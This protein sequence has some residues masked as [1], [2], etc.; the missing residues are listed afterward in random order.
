[1]NIKKLF[2][3]I[4]AFSI[5]LGYSNIGRA[6]VT[7]TLPSGQIAATI[8]GELPLGKIGLDLGDLGG[9]VGDAVSQS[10]GQGSRAFGSAMS[11]GQFGDNL[12]KG[13][14]GFADNLGRGFGDFNRQAN[15]N[16]IPQIAAF[17]RNMGS[18]VLNARNVLQFGGLAA[19][20][21]A[22]PVTGYYGTKFLWTVAEQRLLNP[23]P[24]V[25]LPNAKIGRMDRI[26]RWW[27]GYKT[28]AMIFPQL[29]KDR[30]TEIVEKTK[31]IITHIHNGK[32]VTFDNLLLYGEPGTGKTLFVNILA[33]LTN[34]DFAPTTAAALL[35]KNVGVQYIN[36][37]MDMAKR[38]KYG[39][40]I[41]I[42]E[43]DALFVDRNGLDASSD[44]YQIL[45]HIRSDR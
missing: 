30:L 43:A 10:I 17:A 24:K 7:I 11:D 35:Q 41:F 23:K 27:S 21:I 4:S 28:P 1:M 37:L 6:D 14:T 31:N 16:L 40:I 26:K 5:P 9:Q 20:A 19:L 33:D 8:T 29:V 32:N 2:I 3:I 45:N 44:H 15:K 13:M 39:V 38:S 34:M 36:E 25:L 22:L 12:S 18:S 42:D